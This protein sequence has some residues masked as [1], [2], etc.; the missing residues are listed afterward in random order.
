MTRLVSTWMLCGAVTAASLMLPLWHQILAAEMSKPTLSDTARQFADL[1]L[2]ATKDADAKAAIKAYVQAKDKGSG[3]AEPKP[4]AQKPGSEG[5]ANGPS[6]ASEE[7]L[8]PTAA[9][10]GECHKQI[11]DEWSSSQHAYASISPMCPQASRT[12]W[13]TPSTTT[14]YS[15]TAAYRP[16]AG[17]AR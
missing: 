4:D 3:A 5:E 14:T 7:A 16:D 13:A 17:H 15:S 11:Y 9:Q 2:A 10:C 8:Y 6:L 1:S 12:R